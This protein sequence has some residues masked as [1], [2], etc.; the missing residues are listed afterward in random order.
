MMIAPKFWTE[1]GLISSALLPLSALWMLAGRLRTVLARPETAELPVICVG[2]ISVGG[3]GKTPVTAML[4]RIAKEQGFSPCI[5]MRGYKGRKAGPVFADPSAHTSADIGDEAVMLALTNDVCVSA[6]RI[7]GAR[8]IAAQ[9]KFDLI[10]M[11]DGMQNPWLRKD[12]IITVFDGQSGLG[13]Q[14]ILPAGPLRESVSDGLGRTD[15]I[16]LNGQDETGLKDLFP[17]DLPVFEGQLHPD[18]KIAKTLKGKRLIGFAGIGRPQ[19]FFATLKQTGA[20]LVRELSFADHH[21]YSEADLSRLHQEALQ[22][23]AELVTTH[24]DWVRLPPEWRVR[25]L[26]LPVSFRISRTHKQRLIKLLS[27]ALAERLA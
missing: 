16:I 12:M 19:R 5:L 21:S 1:K 7:R 11:D 24:K 22:A 23:G 14:R 18:Q 15:A 25:V 13:N 10:I 9:N 2:N 26:A 20:E 6:D 3:T 8:F 27:T 17:Q 4:C